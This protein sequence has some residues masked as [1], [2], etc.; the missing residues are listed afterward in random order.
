[1]KTILMSAS[2]DN[3]GVCGLALAE[4]AD[5]ILPK[6]MDGAELRRVIAATLA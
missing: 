5:R 2:F 6:P 3:S 4:A 1:V